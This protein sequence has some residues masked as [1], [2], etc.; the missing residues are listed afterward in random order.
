MRVSDIQTSI[1]HIKLYWNEKSNWYKQVLKGLNLLNSFYIS[2][3]CL[4][5]KW[6]WWW[7][8]ERV[9][10]SL[11]LT[12]SHITD[13]ILHT[14]TVPT[15]SEVKNEDGMR[16]N[17]QWSCQSWSPDLW[18]RNSVTYKGWGRYAEKPILGMVSL[19]SD[20]W[21]RSSVSNSLL[22]FSKHVF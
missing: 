9:T 15:S 13:P 2:D 6:Y 20:F 14:F 19:K 5:V 10:N 8:P 22:Y 4:L 18:H 1:W 16:K 17:L 3:T 11:T 12:P 7:W 21:N